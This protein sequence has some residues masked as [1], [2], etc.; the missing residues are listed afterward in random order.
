M[1]YVLVTPLVM[2]MVL[3]V[4]ELAL[5]GY[6]KSII[7]AA[8]E[9]AVR[10]AAAF[11]GDTA[12]GEARFRMLIA[13]ELQPSTITDLQW[14]GTLDTLTL[15]VRSSLPLAGPLLPVTLT[16]TASAYHEVWS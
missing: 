8:A 6:S 3:G 1:D 12:T 11:D 14:F 5:V 16:T 15:R 4:L 10:V 2:F 13:R 9:D 7:T